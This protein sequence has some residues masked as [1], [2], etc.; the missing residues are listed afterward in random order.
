[1]PSQ[2]SRGSCWKYACAHTNAAAWLSVINQGSNSSVPTFIT[3]I[4][5]Y[6]E[7]VRI[8]SPFLGWSIAGLAMQLLARWGI[9]KFKNRSATLAHSF[10]KLLFL[11]IANTWKEQ[12][13][14][15]LVEEYF[16]MPKLHDAFQMDISNQ[17]LCK[18]HEWVTK[19]ARWQV[20]GFHYR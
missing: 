13:H 1:M 18:Y 16:I 20:S 3:I 10:W 7:G 8:I 11:M 12:L 5:S 14:F 15:R 19:D 6:P 4:V 2:V 17:Q 9:F